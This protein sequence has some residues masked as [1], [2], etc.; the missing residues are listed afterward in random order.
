M[1]SINFRTYPSIYFCFGII[2]SDNGMGVQDE[3]QI[4]YVPESIL[5]EYED[6]LTKVNIFDLEKLFVGEESEMKEIVDEYDLHE[7]HNFLNMFFDGGSG[8]LIKS[9]YRI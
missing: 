8:Y 1:I 9:F 7:V 6:R 3:Y 2:S 5:D 4:A